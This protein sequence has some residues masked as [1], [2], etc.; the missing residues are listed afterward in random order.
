MTFS[1]EKS[2]TTMSKENCRKLSKSSS[3][4]AQRSLKPKPPPQLFIPWLYPVRFSWAPDPPGAVR[5]LFPSKVTENCPWRT[6]Q[7]PLGL[8][9]RVEQPRLLIFALPHL[10]TNLGV[11]GG[12]AYERCWFYFLAF[13]LRLFF[14]FFWEGGRWHIL[15][16][17]DNLG[18]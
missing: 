12:R 7:P 18:I 4:L 11:L 14:W 17:Q 2:I 6:P 10:C 3:S 15:K 13:F 9:Y 16:P 5:P 1:L 8:A